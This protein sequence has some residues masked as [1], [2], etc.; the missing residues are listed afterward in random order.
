MN[1]RQRSAALKRTRTSFETTNR[2]LAVQV[3]QFMG[4]DP[5]LLFPRGAQIRVPWRAIGS[6]LVISGVILLV[7]AAVVT[8]LPLEG[9]TTPPF[10][11]YSLSVPIPGLGSPHAYNITIPVTLS[12]TREYQLKWSAAQGTG[13]FAVVDCATGLLGIGTC[14]SDFASSFQ[15]GLIACFI[16][17]GCPASGSVS[18][19]AGQGDY[20]VGVYVGSSP[21][22]PTAS[23][24]CTS[25]D[26]GMGLAATGISMIVAGV[27]L[28]YVGRPA[29]TRG[30]QP[31]LARA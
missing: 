17:G 15:G 3:I 5:R 21:A 28:R 25:P 11:S 2:S 26:W 27:I 30:A 1:A 29:F 8:E 4:V 16:S 24:T 18:V 31:R 7:L 12:G 9:Q 20:I 13:I 19:A 23:L 14:L 10:S 22:A 6:L